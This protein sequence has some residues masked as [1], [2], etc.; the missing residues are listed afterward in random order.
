MKL[1]GSEP[2]FFRIRVTAAHLR[3]GGTEP[4]VE[5]WMMVVIREDRVGRQ[6]LTRGVGKGSS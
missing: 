4:E 6:A 3:T 2:G 1:L 5:E